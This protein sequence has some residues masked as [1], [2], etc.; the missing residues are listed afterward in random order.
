MLQLMKRK[1]DYDKEHQAQAK[2]RR[3]R[4]VL[5][6][7][8]IKE[9]LSKQVADKAMGLACGSGLNMEEQDKNEVA[10]EKPKTEKVCVACGG[11]THKTRRA[12][13]CISYLGRKGLSRRDCESCSLEGHGGSRQSCHG[14]GG[15]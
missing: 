8:N 1:R 2:R 14:R 15:Q 10:G 7:A 5:K 6:F 13:A 4:S 9:D 12:K 3:R 11:S